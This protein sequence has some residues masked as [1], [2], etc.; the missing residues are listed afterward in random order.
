MT[1]NILRTGAFWVMFADLDNGL[2]NANRINYTLALLN[3]SLSFCNSAFHG[4]I[5]AKFGVFIILSVN[6]KEER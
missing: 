1:Q 4:M 3:V 6:D 5:S 2:A